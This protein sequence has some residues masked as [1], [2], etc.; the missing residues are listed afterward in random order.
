VRSTAPGCLFEMGSC[1]AAQIGLKLRA[2][3]IHLPQPLEYL[4]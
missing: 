2:Q 4:G 1:Y 3:A